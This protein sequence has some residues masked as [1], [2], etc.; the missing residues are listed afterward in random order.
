MIPD[1]IILNNSSSSSLFE[2][3]SGYF[4]VKPIPQER[5]K[6]LNGF[7]RPYVFYSRSFLFLS[8]RGRYT[9]VIK[10]RLYPIS[11]TLEQREKEHEDRILFSNF[12]SHM[13]KTNPLDRVSAGY[14]L[15]HP[16]LTVNNNDDDNDDNDDQ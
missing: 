4:S 10:R 3:Q 1:H 13:L 14:L 6:E 7:C 15:Q 11:F 5:I 8:N 9:E 12:L 16:F 2:L